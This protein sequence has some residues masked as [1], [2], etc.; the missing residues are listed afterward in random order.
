MASSTALRLNPIRM[1]KLM[2][3]SSDDI[4]GRRAFV[5]P[6]LDDEVPPAAKLPA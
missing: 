6:L 1:T 4:G 3:I 5:E 2:L